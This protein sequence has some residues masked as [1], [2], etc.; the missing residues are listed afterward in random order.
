[1]SESVNQLNNRFSIINQVRVKTRV[2]PMISDAVYKLSQFCQCGGITFIQSEIFQ[3]FHV[4]NGLIYDA[5][6]CRRL[7]IFLRWYIIHNSFQSHNS[8]VTS[9]GV[10]G[11]PTRK[12]SMRQ[13]DL[14]GPS[15]ETPISF[16]P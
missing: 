9:I 3:H 1:M 5:F 4:S 13:D 8:P 6:Y 11:F 7:G 14:T 2:Y 10:V 12:A 16:L 15:S